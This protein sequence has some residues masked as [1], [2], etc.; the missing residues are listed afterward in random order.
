MTDVKDCAWIAQL[1][2]HGLVLCGGSA[3]LGVL[4]E[5]IRASTGVPVLL[6]EDPMRCVVIGAGRLLEDAE[7]LARVQ[8]A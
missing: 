7:V 4:Q 2:E 3:L 8:G 1:L 5:T 6:A